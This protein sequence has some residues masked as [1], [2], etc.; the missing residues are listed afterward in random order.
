MQTRSAIRQA[1]FSKVSFFFCCLLAAGL[2]YACQY[3]AELL[4]PTVTPLAA[5]QPTDTQAPLPDLAI[6]Q[7]SIDPAQGTLCAD[8]DAPLGIKLNVRNRGDAQAGTFQVEVNGERQEVSGLPA[9]G[10]A[11]LWF[12][13]YEQP[14]EILLD[15]D[16]RV[17]ESDETNNRLFET[18][19]LPTLPPGCRPDPTPTVE[20]VG[21]AAVL[22]GHTG[23]VWS[24]T[25]SPDG[26]LVASGSVDN[27]LRLWRVYQGELLRTMTG[28]P[29]PVTEVAF[30]PNGT[31]L[32]TGSY[33]GLVRLW[34]VSDGFLLD[35]LN[36]HAGWVLDVAFS[37]DGLQL[38]SCA[39]DFT[40]RTWRVF[41][42]DALETID[43]GMS[44]VRSLSYSPDG[45]SLVWA[46]TN[47]E[48][49]ARRLADGTSTLI[50]E[51][52]G[53]PALGVAYSPDGRLL[54]AGFGD[55]VLRVWDQPCL[56]YTSPSPRD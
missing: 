3:N 45:D 13:G 2:L 44:V 53:S 6:G 41:N 9:G 37:P 1:A 46:E 26:T 29:F 56:L 54:A 22:Q 47:G 38:A 24:V 8:P 20:Q 39:E 12:E 25:F 40:V 30:S 36:G 18:L 16:N 28:H 17:A 27:T 7:V 5:A 55:H 35:T 32:A 42:G 23:R 19:L 11:V 43:E 15:P 49:R 31:L 10:T 4:P 21:P 52:D 33:D 14:T 50:W 48:I 34:R 51:A